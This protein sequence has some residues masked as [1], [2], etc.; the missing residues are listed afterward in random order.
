MY[1]ACAGKNKINGI[2][3]A[4]VLYIFLQQISVFTLNYAHDI[5]LG[6]LS[7]PTES[8]TQLSPASSAEAGL[9]KKKASYKCCAELGDYFMNCTKAF[10]VVY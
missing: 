4:W 3:L 6:F 2:W 9:E 5:E 1:W 8:C 10:P 7:A